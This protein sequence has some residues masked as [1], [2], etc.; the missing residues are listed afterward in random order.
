MTVIF[1]KRTKVPNE[2][3]EPK[4]ETYATLFLFFLKRKRKRKKRKKERE[5]GRKQK[6][7]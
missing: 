1:F 3:Y 6:V 7:K 4:K 2:E 5:R